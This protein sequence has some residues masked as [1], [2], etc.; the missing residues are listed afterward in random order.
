MPELPEVQGLATWL[1]SKLAG[2]TI[3]RIRL[4][5]VS[6]LKTYDPP[7]SSLEGA[8]VEGVSRRGK[9]LAIRALLNQSSHRSPSTGHSRLA[10]LYLVI[11]LSRAGW[12]RWREQVGARKPSQRGP[13]VAEIIFPDG[14]LDVTEQGK[15]KRL[16]LWVVRHLEDVRQIAGLGPDALDPELNLERFQQ[17]VRQQTGTIK[18]VLSDQ[19][20]IAG[21]GN[22]YSDDILHAAG[23]SPFTR[24]ST[25]K[26]R[27]MADLFQTMQ[28]IMKEA[29]SRASSLPGDQLKDDKRSHFRV[30][31]RTGQPCP[32]CGDTIRA[33]YVGSRS[34][35]YC[36]R[37]QSEGRVYADRRLSRLLR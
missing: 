14:C 28:T 2:S 19:H 7:I 11:H 29:V 22:A 5:S 12:I 32:V 18:K 26:D 3:E 16:A 9:Y 4:R 20:L 33:V 31:G 17:I 36:P 15:E 25:L 13:L 1:T 24:A 6:A 35:Q 21:I 23:F 10:A 27:Q 8:M 37:C 34:F 30:H